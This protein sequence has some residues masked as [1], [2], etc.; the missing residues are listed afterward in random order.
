MHCLP[1]DP[2][3]NAPAIGMTHKQSCGSVKYLPRPGETSEKSGTGR[4]RL[5]DT[6]HFIHSLSTKITASSSS[7][8]S[9]NTRY[10]CLCTPLPYLP[11]DLTLNARGCEPTPTSA[12]VNP[13]EHSNQTSASGERQTVGN[14]TEPHDSNS[15]PESLS[16]ETS[17][18]AIPILF[19]V[20]G[21]KPSTYAQN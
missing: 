2:N 6:G 14:P 13:L 8:A 5:S 10:K 16:L 4:S 17:R 18:R 20:S 15:N 12:T 3:R 19:C 7:H 11:I 1:L 9:F 21:C